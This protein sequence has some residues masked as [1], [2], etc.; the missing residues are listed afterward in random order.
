MTRQQWF[1]SG[2]TL[3]AALSLGVQAGIKDNRYEGNIFVIYGGNGFIIPPKTT[4]EASIERGQAVMLIFYVNDS[5]D[6][7]AYTPAITRLQVEF[8]QQVNFIA[9]HVDG[10]PELS[11]TKAKQYFKGQIPYTVLFNRQGKIIYEAAGVR[12]YAE[13][14]PYLR[15]MAAQ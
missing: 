12:P 5:K 10:L 9:L 13:L 3:I 6:C 4:L 14:L 1:I 7:K 15:Q 2:V 11:G 8:D